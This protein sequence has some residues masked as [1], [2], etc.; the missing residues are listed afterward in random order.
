MGDLVERVGRS[1]VLPS[2]GERRRLRTALGIQQRE[3][4]EEVGVSVQSV[5]AWEQGRSEPTG[6]NRERYATLLTQMQAALADEASEVSMT[7]A[8]SNSAL[9]CNRALSMARVERGLSVDRLAHLVCSAAESRTP[10]IRLASRDNVSR[11]IKRIEAGTVRNPGCEYRSLLSE[12]LAKSEVELFGE[13]ALVESPAGDSFA[14]ASH[15]FVP[16]FVGTRNVSTLVEQFGLRPD[17]G[18]DDLQRYT[19]VVQHPTGECQLYVYPF[20]VALF[21]LVEPVALPSISELARWRQRS[22]R[23]VLRWA[24][25]QLTDALGDSSAASYVLSVYL[26]RDGIWGPAELQTAMRLLA[27][28]RVLLGE[29]SADEAQ[30]AEQ[31]E[32]VLL[33]N[34]FSHPD[35]T[36]FGVM[37]LSIGCASW[38]GVSYYPLAPERALPVDEI[39]EVELL[40]QALWCYCHHILEQVEQARD[41]AIP[42]KYGF[43]FLRGLRSRCF[44]A[45]PQESS[46]HRSMR[47]AILTTSDLGEKLKDALEILQ[48]G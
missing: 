2:A 6:R 33:R 36:E 35:I 40:V 30:N 47:A 31:V 10:P 22:Y 21:H 48:D 13:L 28:P 12:V 9:H 37:G 16:C 34:G 5:W 32:A 43:R 17:A 26:L 14:L 25:D 39:V 18:H 23:D 27:M 4:A 8:V 29:A 19:G 11:H 20:G 46:Q 24:S 42:D 7:Q 15:K 44:T 45:R 41:P 3:V 38:S 1:R